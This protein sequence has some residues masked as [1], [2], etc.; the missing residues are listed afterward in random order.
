[1]VWS[2][3]SSQRDWG[4]SEPLCG[5]GCRRQGWPHRLADCSCWLDSLQLILENELCGLSG[6][7]DWARPA[8]D[9][10]HCSEFWF[11]SKEAQAGMMGPVRL[12]PCPSSEVLLVM[13]CP[14]S[15]GPNVDVVRTGPAPSHCFCRSCSHRVACAWQQP[16][17]S[18]L[19]LCDLFRAQT[20]EQPS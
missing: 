19:I 20:P 4:S 16:L 12:S 14:R 10:W 6:A 17:I 15:T 13:P 3:L 8:L 1:M 7:A 9:S 18:L 5:G 2:G 11:S